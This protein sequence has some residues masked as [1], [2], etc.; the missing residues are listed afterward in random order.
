M[1]ASH[2]P[3]SFTDA[4][5]Q[6]RKELLLKR[7]RHQEAHDAFKDLDDEPILRPKKSK[8]AEMPKVAGAPKEAEVDMV[9]QVLDNLR[10]PGPPQKQLRIKFKEVRSP[11]LIEPFLAPA[12]WPGAQEETDVLGT[13][14]VDMLARVLENLRPSGQ[15]QKQLS[16]R[17]RGELTVPVCLAASL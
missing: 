1:T 3:R 16:I 7:R 8:E 12:C 9:G 4:C 15:S 5:Q 6:V 10:P 11:A 14:E 13:A 2:P 17:F